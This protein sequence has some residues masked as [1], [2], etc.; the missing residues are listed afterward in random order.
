MKKL[1]AFFALVLTAS[2]AVP[3]SANTS[4]TLVII[5]SGINSNLPWVKSMLIEEACFIEYGKC[6]NGQASMV[7][8]GAATLN[9][10]DGSPDK[11]FNHGTQMASVAYQVN[12]RVKLIMIRII[13]RS[14]KGFANSY[15][16]RAVTQ[17]LNW[18]A[19]NVSTYNIG[20]VS[21][22]VG[23]TY[24]EDVCPIESELQQKVVELR[25]ANVA[26]FAASGNKSLHDRVD[27]PSCIPEMITVG[28]TDRRYAMR[29]VAGW[30]YPIMSNSN[31]NGSQVDVFALGRYTTV[32][33]DGKSTV[34]LGTSNATVAM[35]SRWTQ[36]ISEGLSYELAWSNLQSR[37]ENAYR[38]LSV[39]YQLQYTL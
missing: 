26:V 24:K 27:Y 25:Q 36:F 22:S 8:P 1:I 20:A 12:P 30:V 7:G 19:A 17:A 18:V 9:G 31:G 35:A 5:D 33:L 16:T 11:S 29:G 4:K 15:T 21:L 28:A 34:S 23:R 37:F 14:E 10:T 2:L 13:G 39:V 32:T 3:A 6:P 38:S